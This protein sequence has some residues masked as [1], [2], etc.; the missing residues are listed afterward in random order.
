MIKESAIRKE[1]KIYTGRRHHNI[2]NDAKPF[3]FLRNGE[4]GF[5]D[6]EGNFL[7]REEAAIKA[8]ECGQIKELKYH[9]AKLFSEDLY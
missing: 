2:L 4:Q 7:T 5:V 1:G 9:K 8:I 3:G 6:N